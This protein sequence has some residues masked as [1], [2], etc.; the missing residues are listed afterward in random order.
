MTYIT[1]ATAHLHTKAFCRAGA[2]EFICSLLCV[3]RKTDSETKSEQFVNS[4]AVVRLAR[5]TGE[6]QFIL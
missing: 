4:N 6:I 5:G 3:Q 1:R 2:G